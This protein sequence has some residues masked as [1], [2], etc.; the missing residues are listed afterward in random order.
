MKSIFLVLTFLMAAPCW[1]EAPFL[2]EVDARFAKIE[3]KKIAHFVYDASIGDNGSSTVNSGVHGLGARLPGGAVITKDWLFF[4][5]QF[6]NGNG[7]VAFKC[8]DAG[9]ILASTKISAWVAGTPIP[10]VNDGTVS[11]YTGNIAAECEITATVVGVSAT[12]GKLEGFV[13][14]FVH[15]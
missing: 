13:E 3:T 7:G 15:E 11:A 14:Y 6:N 1:A 9:N 4:D 5:S 12:A 10:A 8:E 2:P